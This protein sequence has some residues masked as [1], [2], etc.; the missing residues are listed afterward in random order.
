[1]VIKIQRFERRTNPHEDPKVW[2]I[3]GTVIKKHLSHGYAKALNP[4][5]FWHHFGIEN[6]HQINEKSTKADPESAGDG[7]RHLLGALYDATQNIWKQSKFT[8]QKN[9][10]KS[11]LLKHL[12][13]KPGLAGVTE[14]AQVFL[15]EACEYKFHLGIL[16]YSWYEIY[17]EWFEFVLQIRNLN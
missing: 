7:L 9:T 3:L 14:S 2:F 4:M 17:L 6:R 8:E 11:Q 13:C 16:K 15:F 5:W 12:G 1:M 10:T